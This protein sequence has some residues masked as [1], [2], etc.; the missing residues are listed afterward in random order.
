MEKEKS[1]MIDEFF[2]IQCKNNA[3]F[4]HQMKNFH[5]REK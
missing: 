4:M 3:I 2:L 5:L 1:S